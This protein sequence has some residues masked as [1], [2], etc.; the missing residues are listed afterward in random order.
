M[1]QAESGWPA[2][3]ASV[4]CLNKCR[5]NGQAE[6]ETLACRGQGALRFPSY[7]I[8]RGRLVANLNSG[9]ISTEPEV[10][11]VRKVKNRNLMRCALKCAISL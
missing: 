6:N 8:H 3:N 4:E 1:C 7:T 9:C 11:K 2:D 10:R 5:V